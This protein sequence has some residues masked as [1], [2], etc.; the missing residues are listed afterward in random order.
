MSILQNFAEA[1]KAHFRTVDRDGLCGPITGTY[2]DNGNTEHGFYPDEG[3]DLSKLDA[4]ID[5]FVAE[6]VANNN[7]TGD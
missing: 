3:L 7:Q 5:A 6:F 4:E 1:L 2:F